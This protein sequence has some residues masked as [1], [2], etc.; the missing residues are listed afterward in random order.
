MRSGLGGLI[1]GL[2]LSLGLK[3]CGKPDETGEPDQSGP[4]SARFV[5]RGVCAPC[6]QRELDLWAGS[7]HDLAMQIASDETVLGDFDDSEFTHFGVISNFYKREGQFLVRTQ[8]EDGELQEFEVSHTFGVEPLQQYLIR[9]PR[10]RFQ[11][12]SICWDTRPATEGGQRWFH[13]Y[14]DE[15][16]GPH[17]PLHWTGVYQTWNHQCAECHSTDLEKS[18]SA[19]NAS[20]QT[21]WS[22]IDVSCEACHG[23]GSEHV[24]WAQDPQS[25]DVPKKDGSMG[26]VV[27]LEEADDISWIFDPGKSI[28]RRNR[29]RSSQVEIETCGRCHSR[30]SQ[31]SEKYVYGKP[32]LDTHRVTLLEEDLYYPDGQ[33]QD[34]VYVYGS[35]LQSKMHRK[36]VSCS[37]CHQ[38]HSLGLQ[39]GV[40]AVCRTCHLEETYESTSHHFHP[41]GSSGSSCVEC[42]M[43]ARKYMVLDGRRDHSF[44]VPSPHLS[45]KLGTPNAC[46]HCHQDRPVQWAADAVERWYGRERSSESHYGETLF[47]GRRGL[48]GAGAKL[49]ALAQDESAPGIARAS[50]LSLLARHATAESTGVIRNALA[51]SDPLIRIAAAAAAEM[52]EPAVRLEMLFA[53]LTDPVRAVRLEAVRALADV[54]PDSWGPGRLA[55]RDLVLAEYREAFQ[56]QSDRAESHYNLGLLHQRL[57]DSQEAEEAYQKAL[58]IAPY[59]M[60]AYVNLADLYRSQGRD[61]EGEELLLS[62]LNIDPESAPL[63]HSLGLLLVRMQRRSEAL[64]WLQKAAETQPDRA[65]YSYVYGVALQSLGQPQ[66]ALQVLRTAHSSHPGDPDLLMALVTLMRQEGQPK[67]ALQ[68]A[69]KLQEL[70]PGNPGIVSLLTQLEREIRLAER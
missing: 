47:A 28:A 55:K 40:D 54:P 4:V 32:L 8:G 7:H 67:L 39:G 16:I 27:R 5:G 36:G 70:L 10:G 56:T 3:G 2:I 50:A 58:E 59:S 25:G 42:H 65:R 53:S 66:Q 11:A 43:P 17:D 45:L 62:G 34:E 31:L 68:Y 46:N 1:F 6:H 48:P 15:E 63:Q 41:P 64:D 13:L 61:A 52:V 60:L 29:P 33:I 51:N 18:Y 35:F 26:L 22:E 19:E 20:Y 30:R 49:L 37:D 24:A 38:P 9:F 14:G 57:G 12:L 23:P 69:R 44:R 21:T